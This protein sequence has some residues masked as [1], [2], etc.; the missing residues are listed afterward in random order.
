MG[1][2]NVLTTH[3]DTTHYG[4]D[5][6]QRRIYLLNTHTYIFVNR[7]NRSLQPHGKIRVRH[8]IKLMANN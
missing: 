3:F 8:E 5:A 2:F 7:D 1:H 6:R 4:I